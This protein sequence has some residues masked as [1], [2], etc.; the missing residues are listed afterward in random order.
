[1]FRDEFDPGGVVER[2][3]KSGTPYLYFWF[4]FFSTFVVWREGRKEE[5]RKEKKEL[6]KERENY[7][8]RIPFLTFPRSL[9]TWYFTLF[10][11]VECSK[12]LHR[13]IRYIHGLTCTYLYLSLSDSVHCTYKVW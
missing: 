3:K 6:R 13:Y 1:M 10:S 9:G 8:M 4:A 7:L 2:V 11:L 5:G 12:E